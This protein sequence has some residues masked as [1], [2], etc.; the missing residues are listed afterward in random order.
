MN[1]IRFLTGAAVA[2]TLLFQSA[3]ARGDDVPSGNRDHRDATVSWTKWVT[4]WPEN[5]GITGVFGIIGG[6]AEGDI[7]EGN[8]TGE[9]L[10]PIVPLPDGIHIRFEADYHFHGSK[11][12][13]TVHFIVTQNV[14]D[15]GGVLEGVVTD[16]W[17]KGNRVT[18]RFT[19][20]ECG[21]GEGTISPCFEG[22]AEIER[23][24]KAKD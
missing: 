19:A 23:G 7:G 18:G 17:L 6:P 2:A 14:V 3:V 11:H 16:G 15:N 13:L 10:N 1:T 12:S 22:T 4:D 20:R 24:S 9:A 21:D 5:D 8:V